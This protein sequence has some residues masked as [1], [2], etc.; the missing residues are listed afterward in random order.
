MFLFRKLIIAVLALGLVLSFGGVAIGAGYDDDAGTS[1]ADFYASKNAPLSSN[2]MVDNPQDLPKMPNTKALQT[3]CFT[4]Y[5]YCGLAYYWDVFYQSYWNERFDPAGTDTLKTL[6]FYFYDIGQPLPPTFDIYVWPTAG[7]LPDFGNEVAMYTVSTTGLPGYPDA[8]E[9]DVSADDI[10]FDN[11]YHVGYNY[12]ISQGD[13]LILSDAGSCY[14]GRASGMATA[15]LVPYGFTEGQFYEMS[16]AWDPPG[17]MLIEVDACTEIYIECHWESYYADLTHFTELGSGTYLGRSTLINPSLGGSDVDYI[18]ILFYPSGVPFAEDFEVALYAAD[19]PG[20]VALTKIVG[21]TYNAGTDLGGPLYAWVSFDLGQITFTEP[22]W[23]T[24]ESFATIGPDI[25]IL[26]CGGCG[27][28]HGGY[29]HPDGTWRPSSNDP[30]IDVWVCS[31]PLPGRTCSPGEEWPTMGK[32]F[33]RENHSLNSIGGYGTDND[34]TCYLTK[35]W[36]YIGPSNAQFNSPVLADGRIVV[37]MTNNLVCIDATDGDELWVNPA[38]NIYFGASGRQTPTIYNGLVYVSGGDATGFSAFNLS[39]GSPAWQVF[40]NSFAVYGP[41]VVVDVGGTDVVFTSD[42]QGGVYAFNAL[43]GVDYYASNPFMFATG[44]VHKALST[45]GDYVY[46]GCDAFQNQAELYKIDVTDGSSTTFTVDGDGFQLP[47]L[48]TNE[49]TAEGIFSAMA[50]EDGFIYFH[51]SYAPQN[52]NPVT[53]GGLLYKVQTSDLTIAWVAEANGAQHGDFSPGGVVLDL[54]AVYHAGH[55]NWANHGG[56]FWGPMSYNKSN[57]LINWND[58]I[59]NPD[60][61]QNGA[62]AMLLTCE[63]YDDAAVEDWLVWGTWDRYVQFIENSVGTPVFHR[64]FELSTAAIN[65]PIMNQEYLYLS[66]LDI[67]CAMKNQVA[68][69]PRLYLPDGMEVAIPVEFGLPDPYDITFPA[70][71]GNNGCAELEILSLEVDAEDNGTY[72]LTGYSSV[73]PNRNSVVSALADRMADKYNNMIKIVPEETREIVSSVKASSFDRAAYTVPSWMYSVTSPSVG[74][75]VAPGTALDV[76]ISINGEMLPRG[77]N[78][79]YLFVGTDDPDYF[80]D[81]AYMDNDQ[82]YGIPSVRLAVVGGCIVTSYEY[83]FGVGGHNSA[84]T[85]NTTRIFDEIPVDAGITIDG[86]NNY[87]FHGHG[88]HYTW[89]DSYHSVM[90]WGAPWANATFTWDGILPD[91]YFEMDCNFF[92]DEAKLAEMSTDGGENYDD[93][94]GVIV[95]YAYVDSVQDQRETPETDVIHMDSWNWEYEWRGGGIP[96]YSDSLTEGYAFRT[97]MSEYGVLDVEEFD[98]IFI[99]RFRVYSRYGYPINSIGIAGSM[100]TDVR[101]YDRNIVGYSSKYST[102][103]TWDS[104]DDQ[105]VVGFYK[106]PFGGDYDPMR[107]AI[108]IDYSAWTFNPDPEYDSIYTFQQAEHYN[109]GAYDLWPGVADKRLWWTLGVFDLPA[110]DYYEGRDK[111]DVPDSAF[112]DIGSVGYLYLGIAATDVETFGPTGV[113]VNKFCGFG[114]GDVNDDGALNLID[115]IY[116]NNA[117]FHAGNGPFPFKHLGDTNGDGNFDILDIMHMID[118]YFHAGPAPV[119]EWALPVTA[120]PTP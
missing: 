53:N 33:A 115:I 24:L 93:V 113:L 39:D 12:D 88:Y 8:F 58:V 37:A 67:I 84:M 1:L 59:L 74:A 94:Y 51:T 101:Q 20:G 15:E 18:D 29:K 44:F 27:S 90:Q 104:F 77:F 70:V 41:S 107:N 22:I 99:H 38:D 78:A 83:D 119:G 43:T 63:D 64:R 30:S 103:Y 68:P 109:G 26:Y 42:D 11:S 120:V 6:R 89:Q 110:W 62:A 9:L 13:V 14:T 19:G 69:R 96:P 5:Y 56:T 98:N 36:D 16:E 71:I 116:M 25:S 79:F 57:G 4:V 72:P 60:A 82:D 105:D 3:D 80:L 81:H 45:D 66:S 97:I 91:P 47:V 48:H 95:N 54:A 108:N 61:D 87:F 85:Y 31:V 23:A 52:T 28:G 118:W 7:G 106:I 100:D 2:N 111:D 55:S 17:D 35:D 10:V 112:I 73:N 50:V 76:D 92:V 49:V 46:V 34:A 117:V 114:R 32:T 86:E 102:S 40:T 75:T 21:A 65:A